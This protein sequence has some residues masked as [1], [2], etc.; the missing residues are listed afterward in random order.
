[1][2]GPLEVTLYTRPGCHLCEEVKIQMAPLLL[3]FGAVLQEVNI[4]EDP[5]LRERYT[6]DVPVVFLGARKVAKH[7]VAL[8]QLRR[9]LEAARR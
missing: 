7:R 5:I 4:D 3:E 6:N 2:A 1:M 9:Q 8:D